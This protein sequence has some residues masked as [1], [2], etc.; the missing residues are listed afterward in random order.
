M[1]TTEITT[2]TTA[3]P[4]NL[5]SGTVGHALLAIER[6]HGGSAPWSAA[7][8]LLRE[9]TT[10]LVTD[11][12]AGAS[13]YFGAPAVGLALHA[14]NASTGR[15]DLPLEQ[16]DAEVRALTRR[17][18]DLAHRRIDQ[19][20]PVRLSEFD[21]FYGLTGLG[22]YHLRRASDPDSLRAVLSYLVRLTEQLPDGRPGWW[23]DLDPS[24]RTSSAF[25]N[26][27]GNAGTAHGICGPL[28]LLALTHLHGI[29]VPD[30]HQAIVRITTW[31]DI[32]RRGAAPGCWWPEWITTD[33][34]Q[35]NAADHGQPTRPSWCYGVPGQARAQQLAAVALGD[36][37]R[38][39]R[40]EQAMLHSLRRTAR[41]AEAGLCHGSAGFLLLATR[42]AADASPGLFDSGLD[43]L[44]SKSHTVAEAADGGFLNGTTG[45]QLALLADQHSGVAHSGWDVFLL[46][47]PMPVESS[48]P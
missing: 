46:A 24:G 10:A 5:A 32:N 16:I 35:G 15:Y 42:I 41:L 40:A 9:C 3:H 22:V 37:D 34:H 48:T 27:H 28:T 8:A 20:S 13:L 33:D 30:H 29:R 25:P 18:L 23:T 4:Q 47:Q 38:Q 39:H 2:P 11:E 12:K 36:A 26:G 43:L 7:H 14:A 21:F 6:A 44:R 19:G 1:T 31:L 17:R 45:I